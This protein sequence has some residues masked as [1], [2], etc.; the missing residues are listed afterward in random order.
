MARQLV[1]YRNRKLYDLEKHAYV[2]IREVLAAVRAGTDVEITDH[3]SH[4]NMTTYVLATALAAEAYNAPA[5]DPIL[6]EGL[7]ALVRA[8]VACAP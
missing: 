7:F 8:T 6:L 1:R 5:V 2:S 3:N 4:A